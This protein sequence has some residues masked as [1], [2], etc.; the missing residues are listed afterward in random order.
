MWGLYQA[1]DLDDKVKITI[2]ASGF[3][4]TVAT[5]PTKQTPDGAPAPKTTKPKHVNPIDGDNK[6]IKEMYK[7]GPV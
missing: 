6:K 3:E 2:L 4:V 7:K 1:P 5:D